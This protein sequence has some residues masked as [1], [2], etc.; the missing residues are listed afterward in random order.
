M[1][2]EIVHKD[3]A[4]SFPWLCHVSSSLCSGEH[5][6]ETNSMLFY[7]SMPYCIDSIR[8]IMLQSCR[9]SEL[10]AIGSGYQDPTKDMY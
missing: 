7:A 9:K 2:L 3:Q 6:E 10:K 4:S 1:N 8:Q 5:L